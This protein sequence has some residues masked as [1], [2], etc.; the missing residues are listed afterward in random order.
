MVTDTRPRDSRSYHDGA[1]LAQTHFSFLTHRLYSGA[2]R[3]APGI[4]DDP[5]SAGGA[6]QDASLQPGERASFTTPLH[7]RR[8]P[9]EF[10]AENVAGWE[11]FPTSDTYKL[12]AP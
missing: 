4:D 6:G 3:G 1:A 9:N 12:V 8:R 2:P 7:P 5:K 10:S 11:V